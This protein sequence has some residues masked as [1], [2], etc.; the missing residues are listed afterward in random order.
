MKYK[1]EFTNCWKYNPRII[2]VF[3]IGLVSYM[4]FITILNFSI[5]LSRKNNGRMGWQTVKDGNQSQ[6]PQSLI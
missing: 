3:S 2:T 6:G 4:K 1:L 5:S